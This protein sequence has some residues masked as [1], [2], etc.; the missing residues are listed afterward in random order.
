MEPEPEPVV[1]DERDLTGQLLAPVTDFTP[2]FDPFEDEDDFDAL[3]EEAPLASPA[4]RGRAG[5]HSTPIDE[6]DDDIDPFADLDTSRKTA[7]PQREPRPAASFAARPPRPPVMQA[8][9]FDDAPSSGEGLTFE[10]EA[11]APVS[12]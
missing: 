2:A 10:D 11:P 3:T 1:A 9:R 12:R 8:P 6:D 4:A 7:P 5:G